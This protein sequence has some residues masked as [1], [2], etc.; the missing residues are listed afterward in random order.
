L[1]DQIAQRLF[2]VVRE[3]AD[4]PFAVMLLAV[5]QLQAERTCND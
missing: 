1:P 2:D 3:L 5:L 4:R